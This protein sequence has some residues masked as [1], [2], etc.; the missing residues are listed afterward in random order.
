MGFLEGWLTAPADTDWVIAWLT[1]EPQA[2]PELAG[3]QIAASLRKV[4]AGTYRGLLSESAAVRA[5][6]RQTSL[7]IRP[8]MRS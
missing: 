1:Q 2:R 7:M 6:R 4:A 5:S 3:E 8:G